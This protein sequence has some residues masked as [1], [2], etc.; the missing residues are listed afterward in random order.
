MYSNYQQYLER[1]GKLPEDKYLTNAQKASETID[2]YTMGQAESAG[3]M[4]I[5]LAVCECDLVDMIHSFSNASM[6]VKSENNDGFSVT[7]SDQRDRNAEIIGVLKKHL[8]FPQ[9]L[10]SVSG[11][12]FV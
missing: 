3:T 4:K 1:G 12:T 6:G 8:T 10:L 5:Q 2:Y 9:N 7:F 11:W